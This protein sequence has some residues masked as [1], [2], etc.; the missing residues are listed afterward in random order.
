MKRAGRP[1][2]QLPRRLR[3]FEP[4]QPLLQL[5]LERT[6]HRL[7]LVTHLVAPIALGPAVFG[8]SFIKPSPVS[9]QCARSNVCWQVK[10]KKQK[11]NPR[12]VGW[13]LGA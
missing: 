13:S 2:S 7:V 9:L 12:F 1:L 10:S 5:E 4:Q 11:N 3:L 6:Q 8:V